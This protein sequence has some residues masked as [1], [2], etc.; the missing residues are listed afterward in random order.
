MERFDDVSDSVD[1][2][3]HIVNDVKTGW[4][5]PPVPPVVTGS[6][7]HAPLPEVPQ[8]NAVQVGSDGAGLVS[9]ALGLAAAILGA[10]RA[11]GKFREWWSLGDESYGS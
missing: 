5:D 2:F 11:F 9:S 7:T 1:L 3:D 4:V 6:V 8:V 10:R